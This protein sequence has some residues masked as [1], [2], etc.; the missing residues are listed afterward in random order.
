M[1]GHEEGLAAAHAVLD[2]MQRTSKTFL[3]SLCHTL[4]DLRLQPCGVWDLGPTA[5]SDSWAS[6]PPYCNA[7]EQVRRDMIGANALF[8]WRSHHRWKF[9]FALVSQS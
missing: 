6:R 4:L 9:E 1:A 7:F 3:T 2:F 5:E 8:L